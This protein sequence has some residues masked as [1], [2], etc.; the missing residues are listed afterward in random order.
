MSRSTNA[1]NVLNVAYVGECAK[2][3]E[4]AEA[5]EWDSTCG[6]AY[7]GC[8]KYLEKRGEDTLYTSVFKGPNGETV[9][10]VNSHEYSNGG[11]FWWVVFGPNADHVRAFLTVLKVKTRI[12]PQ[13][14]VQQTL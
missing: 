6:W 12:K 8:D 13:G 1:A 9:N 7:H 2:L 5:E 14:I 10:V 11:A 4:F 3:N